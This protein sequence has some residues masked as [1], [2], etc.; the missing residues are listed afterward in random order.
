[1][2]RAAKTP[3]HNGNGILPKLAFGIVLSFVNGGLIH[4]VVQLSKSEIS[5]KEKKL[6]SRLSAGNTS[7]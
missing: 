3:N 2:R 4:A 7:F 5:S 6:V 1:M